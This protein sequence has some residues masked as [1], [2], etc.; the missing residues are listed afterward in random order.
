MTQANK[1][2]A[3]SFEPQTR[4]RGKQKPL[5]SCPNQLSWSGTVLED[6]NEL[7]AQSLLQQVSGNG[8]Y[9]FLDDF[10]NFYHQAA[11]TDTHLQKQQTS[12]YTHSIHNE[13]FLC[14]PHT[15]GVNDSTLN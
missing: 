8:S 3:E 15:C 11:A 12:Y 2:E 5:S 1:V 4:G 13:E 7:A 10:D 6:R 9:I 14:F